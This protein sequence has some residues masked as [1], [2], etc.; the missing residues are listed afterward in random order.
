MGIGAD[1]LKTGYVKEGGYNLV[2]SAVQ[3]GQRLIVVVMGA[4]SEKERAEEARKLL[5]WGFRNF[6]SRLLFDQDATIAEARLFGG[7]Q[8]R[9]G[10]VADGP[11]K[12]LVPRGST[13]KITAQ[14]GLSGAGARAG[15][16]RARRSGACG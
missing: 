10:L 6:E 9:V 11:V 15:Q 2:G 16:P 4:K 14:G 8:G 1:G 3:N 13:E 5:D 7:A 12:I